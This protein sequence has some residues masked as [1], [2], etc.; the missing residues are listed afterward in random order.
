MRVDR[1]QVV[2]AR[3]AAHGLHRRA[4]AGELL[5]A[6]GRAG[7]QHTPPGSAALTLH[8]RLDGLTPGDVSAALLDSKDLIQV[9]SLRG[10]P[11]VVPTTD[12]AV[13]TA[14]LRP[15]DE[16]SCARFIQG[17]RDHL[18]KFGLD[19][20]TAVRLTL[21]A[22]PDA[23]DGT[24]TKDE[25]GQRLAKLVRPEISPKKVWDSPDGLRSNTHGESLVRFALYVAGLSATVCFVPETSPARFT[26]TREW[27]GKPLPHNDDAR[28]ELVRR[29][30]RCHGPAGPG[31]FAWW[32]G[33]SPAFAERSWALV[34]GELT[35]V[36]YAGRRCWAVDADLL[37][38]PP[39]PDGVR[40][41]PPYDPYLATKDKATVV[42]DKAWHQ[43][44]WRFSGNPGVVLD[45][46]E[47]AGVWRPRKQ[48]RR[49]T[50]RVE[51][52]ADLPRRTREALEREAASMAP[53]RDVDTVSVEF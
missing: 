16:E 27:L 43:R 32:T 2:R 9:W 14:G 26:S 6:A 30:L 47:F 37:R 24:P 11:H 7:V 8:T 12:A 52:A 53:F 33:A 3:L 36:D 49:L 46:G 29:F 19:A 31:A 21:D 39:E 45:R 44:V 17:A 51:T 10:A 22:L 5:A 40:L 25:L 20:S 13:F 1:R 48:G 35:E 23:L 28:A 38:D 18:T 34:A 50:V 41:L 15:D 42:P 4:P